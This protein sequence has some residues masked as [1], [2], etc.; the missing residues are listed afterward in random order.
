[1]RQRL[2]I[3]FKGKP[4]TLGVFYGYENSNYSKNSIATSPPESTYLL[5]QSAPES[6]I[7]RYLFS[8]AT[9]NA[10]ILL[11]TPPAGISKGTNALDVLAPNEGRTAAQTI[12]DFAADKQIFSSIEVQVLEGDQSALEKVARLIE[13]QRAAA[14]ANPNQPKMTVF[15]RTGDAF[16]PTQV[17]AQTS[18]SFLA[19]TQLAALNLAESIDPADKIRFEVLGS[20]NRPLSAQEI[21]TRVEGIYSGKLFGLELASQNDFTENGKYK[22]TAW[23]SVTVELTSNWGLGQSK[24]KLNAVID[25]RV[26]GQTLKVGWNFDSKNNNIVEI[27]GGE[28]R[29]LV[30]MQLLSPDGNRQTLRQ[31]SQF[32]GEFPLIDGKGTLVFQIL[33]KLPDHARWHVAPSKE[34]FITLDPKGGR[35][36]A[37]DA[38][39]R[40]AEIVYAAQAEEARRIALTDPNTNQAVKKRIVKE[41]SAMT[42]N[43][44][45]EV[46]LSKHTS[47]SVS[48]FIGAIDRSQN[49]SDRLKRGFRDLVRAKAA[50]V[51]KPK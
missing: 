14:A 48:R 33:E 39:D 17:G 18:S 5:T 2:Y 12:I 45:Q 44:K 19:A 47:K 8:K 29:D 34:I 9:K 30:R 37:G 10:G 41:I 25:A 28:S 3:D 23:Q 22:G 26:E 20:D 7:T 50:E 27:V 31:S 6:G 32:Y 15:L 36:S 1:M 51:T 13:A 4:G 21:A 46:R 24:G 42:E 49:I 16:H 40:T 35:A 38:M 11:E 43:D